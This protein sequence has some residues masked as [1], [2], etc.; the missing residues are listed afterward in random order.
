[1]PPSPHGCQLQ[2]VMH[3]RIGNTPCGIS[4][5][6]K[7]LIVELFALFQRFGFGSSLVFKRQL[8]LP[9]CW[10]SIWL[11]RQP[12]SWDHSNRLREF[13]FILDIRSRHDSR[14]VDARATASFEFTG[15]G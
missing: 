7:L 6:W 4:P 1:M 3:G 5:L 11:G 2:L 12:H 10:W 15:W 14:V 9:A 13:R 8:F